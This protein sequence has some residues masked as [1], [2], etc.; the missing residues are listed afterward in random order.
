MHRNRTM[1]RVAWLLTT[2]GAL[3]W[4]F[5]GLFNFNLVESLFG[6]RSFLTNMIYALVGLA[7]AFSL[8]HL[9]TRSARREAAPMSFGRFFGQG[10]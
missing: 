10:D 4:G 1:K 3:N 6:E 9:A 8:Y 7:G 5:K 2:V